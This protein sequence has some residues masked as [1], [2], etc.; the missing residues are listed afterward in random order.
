MFV[1]RD[2]GCF[3][4]GV[5]DGWV[6]VVVRLLL[7]DEFSSILSPLQKTCASNFRVPSESKCSNL[8]IS[9]PSQRAKGRN[10]ER[11]V[12]SELCL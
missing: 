6:V 3:D 1:K 5:C 10:I 9:R 4:I 2:K 7:S 11:S 12:H 8:I